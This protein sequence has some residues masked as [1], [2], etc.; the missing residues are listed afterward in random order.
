MFK[1]I[2]IYSYDAKFNFQ[3]SLFQFSVSHDPSEI[4]KHFFF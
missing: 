4:K 1:K 3:K 2:Y